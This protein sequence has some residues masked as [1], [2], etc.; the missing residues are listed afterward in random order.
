MAMVSIPSIYYY[1]LLDCTVPD[2]ASDFV[3]IVSYRLVQCAVGLP[4]VTMTFFDVVD[5]AV[6]HNMDHPE[7]HAIVFRPL[8]IDHPPADNMD[9]AVVA[10]LFDNYLQMMQVP[11]MEDSSVFEVGM[12]YSC[13]HYD[14]SLLEVLAEVASSL[15]VVEQCWV[16]VVD[17]A[18]GVAVDYILYSKRYYRCV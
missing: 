2:R 7:A 15:V 1:S 16:V 8:T 18:A 4:I 14:C 11:T 17:I 5:L 13:M 9:P 6:V 10:V 3:D 12:V